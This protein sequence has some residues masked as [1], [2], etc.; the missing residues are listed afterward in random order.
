VTTVDA[1]PS[2]A[3]NGVSQQSIEAVTAAKQIGRSAGLIV[4]SSG[5]ANEHASEPPAELI[6]I[7]V[8]IIVM[9]ITF[10]S[11]LA[12]AMPLVSAIVGI[13][14][15]TSIISIGTAFLT[16]GTSTTGL[17]T[18]IGLAVGIDYSLFVISRYRQETTKT[19]DRAHAAG[20][21]VGTAGSA[22]VFAGATASS[23]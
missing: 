1:T 22:V 8:A 2:G 4:E 17:A 6:G 14:L 10:A 23:T 15:S 13:A 16:L 11:L 9:I 18:M 21:A 20:V 19:S 12:A 3:D 5:A 7:G